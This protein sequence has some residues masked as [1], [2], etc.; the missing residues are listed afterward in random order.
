[1]TK[2]WRSLASAASLSLAVLLAPGSA[3][4]QTCN[5]GIGAAFVAHQAAYTALVGAIAP[6]LGNLNTKLVQTVD[7]ATYDSLLTD[8]RTLA[9]SVTSGRVLITVPDGTVVLDTARTDDPTNV[10]PTG[11]SFQH[12]QGKT[13]NENHN[14][15]VAILDAQE[16]PCGFGLEAKFSTSTNQREIYVA[17]RLGTHLDSNGTAR[18]STKE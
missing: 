12:F 4:A 2:S 11:N 3:R 13:V 10:L 16:W 17:V 6:Q 9:A 18:I 14:S 8:A 15:R 1:M 7:Q 5:A